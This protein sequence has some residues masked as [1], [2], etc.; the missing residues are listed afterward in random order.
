LGSSG[1]DG[2]G[3]AVTVRV[4]AEHMVDEISEHFDSPLRADT[5]SAEDE[6]AL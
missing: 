4:N 6:A 2:D 3:D 5:D 1:H